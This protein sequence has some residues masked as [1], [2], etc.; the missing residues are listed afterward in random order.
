MTKTEVRALVTRSRGIVGVGVVMAGVADNAVSSAGCRGLDGDPGVESIRSNRFDI[1]SP[2]TPTRQTTA[3]APA[4]PAR[5]RAPGRGLDVDGIPGLQRQGAGRDGH[6]R[7]G[8]HRRDRP[9]V[10]RPRPA[11]VVAAAGPG[12]HRGGGRR[13]AAALRLP[14]PV[15]ARRARRPGRGARRRG[16]LDAARGPA[17]RGPRARPGPARDP[18]RRRGRL[19]AVR[20]AGQP[21]GRPPAG[22]WGARW[23]AAAR[24]CTRG[25]P[26]CSPTR[27]P[28]CGS[29]TRHVLDLGHTRVA[30]LSMR[31]R[32][33]ARPAGLGDRAGAWSGPAYPDAAGGSPGSARSPATT[34]RSCRR[35]TSPSR[36]GRPRP[37]CS[38]TCRPPAT[39]RRRRPGR[40]ARGRRGAGRGGPRACGCR[41][42]SR[43]PASTAS[44]CPGS[45]TCS[46]PSSSPGAAKGRAMGRLVRRALEGRQIADEPFPVRL[47][48]GTTSSSPPSVTA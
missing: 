21:G 24:R 11:R 7:A 3:G 40:P 48:V 39:D 17:G 29:T 12:G 43:S 6:R 10:R 2:M 44:T 4:H 15:R 26:T 36:P 25:W 34:P 38:S 9:G 5:R 42:T 37:G 28:R 45:T 46:R 18:G 16:P 47:R 41:R 1:V 22:P 14:R 30:H 31:P 19:P 20:R 8:A 32:P 27:P 33:R 23:W 13:G 35:T